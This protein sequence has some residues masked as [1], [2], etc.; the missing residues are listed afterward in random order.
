M[1]AHAFNP[2][3]QEAEAGDLCDQSGLQS[4]IQSKFQDCYTQKLCLRKTKTKNL[5]KSDKGHQT[6]NK[7]RYLET[8]QPI[9]YFIQMFTY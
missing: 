5:C 7:S 4:D 3:T 6:N 1:V 9:P 2:T 8:E